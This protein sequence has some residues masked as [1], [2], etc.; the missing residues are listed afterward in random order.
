MATIT[1]HSPDLSSQAETWHPTQALVFYRKREQVMCLT[2]PVL[3]SG[4]HPELGAARTLSDAQRRDLVQALGAQGFTP[5]Q[6]H[7]LA[8]SPTGVAWW[9]PPGM[10]V[11]HFDAKYERTR[12]IARLSGVPVPLPG[13][14]FL[15]SPGRLSVYAVTGDTRPSL[16]T[17]V[18]HA[19]LWNIFQSGL[20]CQ[21]TTRYP[22][23][24]LPADQ[25]AWEEAFFASLFTGPSRQDRYMNWAR[26]YEELLEEAI[27][28]GVFPEQVLVPTAKTL[29]EVF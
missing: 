18:C 16:D 26:S 6:P 25:A 1:L 13:L 12:S 22:Q 3:T 17:P 20:V 14:V 15:A 8:V 19:P 11:M 9:R 21:G 29:R 7:T 5:T 23:G 27:R 28:Q 4:K 10:A 24:V 2:H